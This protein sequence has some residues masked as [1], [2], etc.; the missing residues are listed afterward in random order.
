MVSR[1]KHQSAILS[2]RL[3]ALPQ[4]I[5]A[6]E[7]TTIA[8]AKTSGAK[9][10]PVITE[11]RTKNLDGVSFGLL[12]SVGLVEKRQRFDAIIFSP[13]FQPQEWLMFFSG[14]DFFRSLE[15]I[16]SGR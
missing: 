2:K 6:D 15:T 14:F 12:R 1:R 5:A 8:A 3:L 13:R 4:Q 16:N 9:L 7:H 11:F 10:L